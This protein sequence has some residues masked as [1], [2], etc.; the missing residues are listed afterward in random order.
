[1]EMS[2]NNSQ[3][4]CS[5]R[6][7][8]EERSPQPSWEHLLGILLQW[9]LPAAPEPPGP[10]ATGHST[11]KR[12]RGYIFRGGGDMWS[13]SSLSLFSTFR[14]LKPVC[15]SPNDTECWQ[16]EEG[17]KAKCIL[18]GPLGVCQKVRKKH[19]PAKKISIGLKEIQTVPW[20]S[21]LLPYQPP[22]H[23]SSF[24]LNENLIQQETALVTSRVQ[25][26]VFL[27]PS[28]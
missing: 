27:S 8:T 18:M 23:S 10:A 3:D 4:V 7:L 14:N 5:S 12:G 28:V 21:Y 20:I 26:H 25:M 11:P 16:M 17:E 24:F 1:M 22:F 19:L 9:H 15:R 13:C 6:R 2:K